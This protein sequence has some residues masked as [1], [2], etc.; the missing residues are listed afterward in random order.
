MNETYRYSRLLEGPHRELETT[1]K[2]I[3]STLG[4]PFTQLAF[5]MQAR[6]DTARMR[7][8]VA[9]ASLLTGNPALG[10]LFD[11][12]GRQPVRPDSTR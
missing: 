6:G 3:A 11:S 10:A 8:Y 1:A 4:L 7:G 9:K 5:A 2:G 12:F